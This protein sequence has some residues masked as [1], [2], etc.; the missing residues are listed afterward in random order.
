MHKQK[1]TI[2]TKFG[3]RK[4]VF[5]KMTTKMGSIFGHK[6]DYYGVG[7]LRG[8]RHIPV[9]SN[10]NPNKGWFSY[11][12]KVP[13]DTAYDTTSTYENI[14]PPTQETSQVFTAGMPA[15]SNS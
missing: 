8:R 12:A 11:A 10:F 13:A 1:V 7:V 4:S 6:I 9:P 14:T 5:P 3:S 15:K 2:Y